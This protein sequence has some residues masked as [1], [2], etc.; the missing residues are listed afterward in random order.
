MFVCFKS[1]ITPFETLS[2]N[3]RK[4]GGNDLKPGI[5]KGIKFHCRDITTGKHTKI[6]DKNN[7]LND[8]IRINE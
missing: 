1:S 6:Y 4:Y 2:S 5:L 7:Y 3:N 8:Y